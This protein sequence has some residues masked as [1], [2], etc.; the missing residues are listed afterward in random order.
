MLPPSW[1]GLLAIY[2]THKWMFEKRKKLWED[3]LEARRNI[4][5]IRQLNT[6][7]IGE[8][9]ESMLTDILEEIIKETLSEEYAMYT[10]I[11]FL[12]LHPFL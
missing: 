11:Y 6:K 1:V 10:W 3:Y 8:N 5:R 4:R 7:I 12:P 9:Y 2:F